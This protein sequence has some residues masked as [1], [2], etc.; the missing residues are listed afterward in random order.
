MR[1][2]LIVLVGLLAGCVGVPAPFIGKVCTGYE[3]HLGPCDKIVMVKPG[4]QLVTQTG[5]KE[6]TLVIWNGQQWVCMKTPECG[7]ELEW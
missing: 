3:D 7:K 5:H 4:V 6:P 2:I 1:A